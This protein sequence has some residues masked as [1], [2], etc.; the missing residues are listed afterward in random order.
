LFNISHFNKH[1]RGSNLMI[2]NKFS[3]DTTLTPLLLF[4]MALTTGIAVASNY[5]AQ[6]LLSTISEFFSVSESKA[7]GIVTAAQLSYALGLLFLVPLGD[8]FERKKLIVFMMILSTSGLLVSAF[9]TGLGWLL[10]GTALAG[11]FSVVAQ[12]LVPYAAVLAE[13]SQKGKAVGFV[14]SGLLLGILLARTFAGFIS[15]VAGWQSVYIVA[16]VLM[17]IITFSL[18]LR[19]PSYPPVASISYVELIK[20]VFSFFGRFSTLRLRALLGFLIFAVFSVL[21]TPLSYMLSE[22]YSFSDM[23]IGA[24]GLAG[25][26]GALLAPITGK[27]SDKGMS[28]QM[29]T[30]GLVALFIS[31][32]FLYFAPSSIIALIIGILLLDAAV[33]AVHIINM[34][35]V[36]K[37]A[38][39]ARNRLNA[40]YMFT[41]FLGGTTGSLSSVFI[42]EHY[43]WN[44]VVIW[45]ALLALAALIIWKI[46]YRAK[47]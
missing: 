18:A 35:E 39:E 45:G 22:Q 24:F 7:G 27:F 40:G 9:S 29:T 34:N 6:P 1:Y 36:Y 42:F 43:R 20:T 8:I 30:W 46:S 26:A 31:W 13:P 44:G 28:S 3:K 17:L 25:A 33:Q 38:T 4:L 19:L 32:G 10:F 5:Y 47:K 2:F 14:M 15:S 21:W 12:V 41:Y 16:A 11:L 23:V 37:L